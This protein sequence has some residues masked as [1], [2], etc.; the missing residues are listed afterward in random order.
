MRLPWLADEP[1]AI[2]AGRLHLRSDQTLYSVG[3]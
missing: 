2:V 3:R 1:D